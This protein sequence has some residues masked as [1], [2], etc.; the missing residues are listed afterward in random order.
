MSPKH[1]HALVIGRRL[2][3]SEASADLSI[4]EDAQMIATLIGEFREAGLPGELDQTAIELA[5]EG[6]NL[7]IQRRARLRAL[8][9]RL[10]AQARQHRLDPSAYGD[11]ENYPSATDGTPARLQAVA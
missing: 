11:T 1:D 5:A 7:A 10:A 4:A 3:A 2:G 6:M 8:H 9:G